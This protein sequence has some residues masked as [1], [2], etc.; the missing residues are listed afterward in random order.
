MATSAMFALVASKRFLCSW[1]ERAE[2]HGFEYYRHGTWSLYAAL[3]VGVFTSVS[4]LGKKAS[5]IHPALFQ[6]SQA[7]LLDLYRSH[8]SNPP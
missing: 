8:P 5:P 2:R 3:D 1:G 4:D 7:L 6:I